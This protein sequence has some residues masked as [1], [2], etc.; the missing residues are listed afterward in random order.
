MPGRVEP[1]PRTRV[2]LELGHTS[3]LIDCHV[4]QPFDL[5]GDAI[6]ASQQRR[7]AQSR[8]IA[9]TRNG[10]SPS[11]IGSSFTEFDVEGDPPLS[12][13]G[14]SGRGGDGRVL[15]AQPLGPAGKHLEQDEPSYTTW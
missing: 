7:F 12:A 13:P 4:H 1:Y 8:E 3:P 14:G 9:A 5:Q 10:E 15:S 2:G 11:A 6:K